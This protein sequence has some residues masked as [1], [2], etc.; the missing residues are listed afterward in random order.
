MHGAL[1]HGRS[2]EPLTPLVTWEDQRCLEGSFLADLSA[3]TGY[4]MSTGFGC[5][6]LAWYV[7]TG[8]LPTEAVGACTIHDLVVAK[9]CGLE[10]PVTDASG[11]ASWGLFDLAGLKW[12]QA[13]VAA[14][15]IPVGILP[16]VLACGAKAGAVREQ[17]AE[18]LRIPAGI[19]VAA[20]IGDNQASVLAV[21][22]DPDTELALNI[23]TGGQ[24]SA[25]LP[26]GDPPETIT[27]QSRHDCRP[28]P[29]GRFVVVAPLLAGGSAW[30]WLVET[31][32]TW[33]EELGVPSPSEDALYRRLNELGLSSEDLLTVKP[34]FLGERYDATLRAS[35][36]GIDLWNFELGS[37]A[38]ALARGLFV[39]LKSMLPE[40]AFVGRGAVVGGGNALRRNPLLQEMARQ[41]FGLPL[42]LAGGR[43]EAA[44]GAALNAAALV[45]R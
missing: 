42:R 34:H 17:E 32:Q 16:A 10:R 37:L 15:G 33:L 14:A 20:A 23:G 29:G 38:R 41:V 30:A 6:T 22:A 2:G 5:A 3:R 4:P 24:L 27:A 1:V 35:I 12:D 31:A 28:F 43:E 40:R 18:R 8:R 9:L 26:K 21:L 7:A 44:C 19:P 39:N 13:A 11:G 36:E 45:T 25:V